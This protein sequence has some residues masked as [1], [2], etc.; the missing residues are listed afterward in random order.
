MA[1]THFSGPVVSPGGFTGPVTGAITGNV[2]GNVTGNITGTVL[3]TAPVN[4][5]AA[6]LAITQAAHAGRVVT[7]NKADGIAVTLPTAT[8]SGSVYR[9]FV[10]TTV[11]SSAITIKVSSAAQ[12]MSGLAVV[13]ADGGDTVVAFE[14]ASDTDTISFNGTTTG[15]ILGDFVELIDVASNK[16]Y[17]RITA[18]ATSSEATPFSATVS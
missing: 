14:T 18:S 10:G 13:A 8:G 9:F 12:T 17:V 6:T 7:L 1:T 2:T 11:T 5:T 3:A 16:Y 4:N 15:G